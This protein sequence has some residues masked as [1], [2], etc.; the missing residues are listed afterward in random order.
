MVHSFFELEF[1]SLSFL[2]ASFLLICSSSNTYPNLLLSYTTALIFLRDHYSSINFLQI[3]LF[4]PFLN[5]ST[6]I[7]SLYWLFLA[8]LL[9]SYTNSSIILLSCSTFFNSTT[10]I[11]LSSLLPNSLFR[12]IKN[13]STIIY[14][15]LPENFPFK[16]QLT[17]LIHMTTS[18]KSNLLLL[19][20]SFSFKYTICMLSRILRPSLLLCWM[21]VVWPLL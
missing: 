6:N 8:I 1:L 3:T 7:L 4:I 13:S 21:F 10:F 9:N 16:Y 15:S 19:L 14:L 17:S 5:S 12:S 18:T 20:F 11:I 2:S